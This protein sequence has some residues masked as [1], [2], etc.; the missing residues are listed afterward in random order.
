MVEQSRVDPYAP[1]PRGIHQPPFTVV[2]R[3]DEY[4][5]AGFEA[6]RRMQRDH[7]WYRGRHRFILHFTR[8]LASQ[9]PPGALEAIDLGGGCGGWISYLHEHAPG[10]FS[11]IALAD[12][13]AA[14]LEMAASFLPPGTA[15]YQIDLLDLQ[16]S[17]RWDVAF[18]L[19]VLEHVHEDVQSLRQIR[20]ALRPG[21]FLVVTSPAFERF[22]TPIDDMSRHVRRYTRSDLADRAAAAGLEIVTSRYF[23]FFLSPLLVLSRRGVPDPSALTP[24]Q[25]RKHL[26]RSARIPPAPLN[27]ALAAVFSLET[28]LGAWL[29]FPWGTSVLAVLRRPA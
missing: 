11:Q 18:L 13:S 5:S 9:R 8:R 2:H 19:D 6:L 26:D 21:G 22:R 15:R 27:E 10:M 17:E 28:P 25:V 12:S 20:H 7:F 29:P 1:D 16:W 4:P 3:E 24:E 14:A 23:M